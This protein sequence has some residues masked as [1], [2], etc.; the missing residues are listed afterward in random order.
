MGGA[1]AARRRRG[2]DGE[3]RSAGA[4]SGLTASAVRAGPT[5]GLRWRTAARRAAALRSPGTGPHY[6]RW[7]AAWV[8]RYGGCSGESKF[9]AEIYSVGV[10]PNCDRL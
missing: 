7:T 5:A 8:A 1:A 10:N 3:L 2:P 4:A 6:G 9:T